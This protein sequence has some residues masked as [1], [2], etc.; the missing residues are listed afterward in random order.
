MAT[1][2]YLRTGKL[3]C[4]YMQNAGLGNAINPLTSLTNKEMYSIPMVI[5]IGHRG[6]PGIKDEPQH[7]FMGRITESL[8]QMLEI[9]IVKLSEKS[10]LKESV[11]RVIELAHRNETPVALLV[12]PE[13]FPK[14]KNFES[15]KKD[16]HAV[17]PLTRQKAIDLITKHFDAGNKAMFFATT[18]YANRELLATRQL[19]GKSNEFDFLNVGAMGH[20]IS[21]ATGFAKFNTVTETTVV[22][23]GDGS[24]LMHL[25]ALAQISA[26]SKTGSS[27][28][29]VIFNN[30]VHDSVG[31]QRTANR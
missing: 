19:T 11:D 4:V 31:G 23:D 15:D 5:I 21:I 24:L 6:A 7:Q 26:L 16:V 1:G 10:L 12:H 13:F 30:G 27:L 9:P 22:L 8:L 20:V 25:G 28:L 29:H 18:G 14:N 17:N 2:S 3:P